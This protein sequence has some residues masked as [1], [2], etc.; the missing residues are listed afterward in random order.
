VA[1]P[2]AD[3]ETLPVYVTPTGLDLK[4]LTQKFLLMS[5]AFSQGAD[6]YLDSSTDGKGLRASNA[7]DGDS[8]YSPLE[9]AWDEG[10]GY[11]GAARDYAAYTDQQIADGD[12]VDTD[13]DGAIDFKT[14]YN[15]GASV[16][17]AKRDLGSADGAK[18][19]FTEEAFQAFVTGRAIISAAGD[20]LTDEQMA[21]L[22]EQRDI[23]VSAWEK[24][25]AATAVHY[26]NDTLQE[27]NKFGTEDYD[28][29]THAKV[30]S[31]LKGFSLG[32]QFNP[33]SPM[34]E[35]SRFTDFH[36]LIKD[37]PV[38]PDAEE[39]DIASYRED[40][41]EARALLGDAYGFDA[42]NLGDENGENGW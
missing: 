39:A 12:L 11:F 9:H 14:E 37:A 33:T 26:I 3:G 20:E 21:S 1:D 8:A 4:Q 22:E 23:A 27:M 10:F 6:D 32:F 29:A 38:L 15:F 30:W 36:T 40:L 19:D 7:Q 35:G 13:G 31:E 16:N 24:A 34:N 17:A 41:I 18:T 2:I 42:A 5:I 28:F 25:I